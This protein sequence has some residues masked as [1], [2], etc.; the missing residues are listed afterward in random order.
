[1]VVACF[2]VGLQGPGCTEIIWRV[3]A[4]FE[5]SVR[6]LI[7]QTAIRQKTQLGSPHPG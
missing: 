3:Q 6:K 4:E 1:M 5:L 2:K 7:D